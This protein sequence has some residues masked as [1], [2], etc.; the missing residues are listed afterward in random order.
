MRQLKW[1]FN[2][3]LFLTD[4]WL[5][6]VLIDIHMYMHIV[7]VVESRVPGRGHSCSWSLRSWPCSHWWREKSRWPIGHR[8]SDSS[9]RQLGPGWSHYNHE[10]VV[11]GA[12]QAGMICFF[13]KLENW[14]VPWISSTAM[15]PKL[16]L[17]ML[18]VKR[19]LKCAALSMT[20]LYASVMTSFM[21][22]L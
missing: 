18:S 3:K 22:G 16:L 10:H 14:A 11:I 20:T 7:G 13:K 4:I 15:H 5:Q 8:Q 6:K 17:V 12:L 19:R 9:L 1:I 2:G 21:L